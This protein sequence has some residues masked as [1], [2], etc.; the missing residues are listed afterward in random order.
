MHLPHRNFSLLVLC[1]VALGT[2]AFAQP[3]QKAPGSYAKINGLELYYEVHGKGRPLV[4]LHG[5]LGS[6]SMFGD[7]LKALAKHYKVIAVDLQGHGRTADIDRPL[8]VELMADD[9]AALIQHLKLGRADVFGYSLGGGVALLV[10]V[11]HP[12]LVNK[13]VIVSTAFRRNAYYPEILA[14]QGQVNEGAAEMMK[15]TPMYQGYVAIAPRPQDFP[16]LLTKIGEA[17]KQDFDFSKQIA[18]LQAPTLVM[19]ADAD[20]FPPSHAV[21]F[22]G[23]LGGGKRDGGW[24]GAGR[25]KSRLA[26]LPGLTHYNVFASPLMVSVALP[27]LQ[28]GT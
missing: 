13:L 22:F 10:G 2:Q 18:S 14:Q 26:I 12:E 21:E 8:S 6:T 27:F 24:D 7:N 11:R 20:L 5:G 28:E 17:M 9:V 4:L 1:L 16:K 25:P 3:K 19:A 23:L 15:Q